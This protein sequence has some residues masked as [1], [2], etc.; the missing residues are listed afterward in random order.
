M[1]N[2]VCPTKRLLLHADTTLVVV[3]LNIHLMDTACG[4]QHMHMTTSI[5]NTQNF[6]ATLRTATQLQLFVS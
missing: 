4:H 5:H 3:Y 2:S 6:P 1:D